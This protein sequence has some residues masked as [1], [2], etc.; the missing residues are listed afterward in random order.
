MSRHMSTRNI[1][2]KSMHAFLSNLSNRETDRQTNKHRQKHIPPPLLKVIKDFAGRFVLLKLTTDRHETSRGLFETA[3][4]LVWMLQ[5]YCSR[6]VSM[7]GVD[8]CLLFAGARTSTTTTPRM[9]AT[10]TKS[11]SRATTTSATTKSP[12]SE[13]FPVVFYFQLQ[14]LLSS[15]ISNELRCSIQLL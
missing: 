1:S 9:V 8:M 15:V 11:T 10:T 7:A 5:E 3:E 4:L 6:P 2:S 13:T 12:S 14:S